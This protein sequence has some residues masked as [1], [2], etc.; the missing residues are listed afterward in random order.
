MFIPRNQKKIKDA[1]KFLLGLKNKQKKLQKDK[2]EANLREPTRLETYKKLKKELAEI[3]FTETENS[4]QVRKQN[5][6]E[7]KQV[8]LNKHD[9][10]LKLLSKLHLTIA[11]LTTKLESLDKEIEKNSKT[12]EKLKKPV[13]AFTSEYAQSLQPLQEELDKAQAKLYVLKTCENF[14]DDPEEFE[15]FLKKLDSFVEPEN[16]EIGS[17]DALV[18]A[19]GIGNVMK[20]N[21]QRIKDLDQ[22]IATYE[23][24]LECDPELDDWLINIVEERLKKE[25]ISLDQK[26]KKKLNKKLADLEF[27]QERELN[28]L[29]EK[30]KDLQTKVSLGVLKSK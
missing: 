21:Y 13:K 30:Q 17:S 8:N 27:V 7:S 24:M 3:E 5:L 22:R 23:M 19:S 4:L 25:Q 11:T 28:I 6:K 16:F 2:E 9:S 20:E 1:Q 14:V 26:Y 12:I 15:K 29:Q 18:G 10:S